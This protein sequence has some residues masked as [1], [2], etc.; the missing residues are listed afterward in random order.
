MAGAIGGPLIALDMRTLYLKGL[1]FFGC[2]WL[3]REVFEN[4]VGYIER[5]EIRPLVSRIYP[6][7]DI[8]QAQQDFMDKKFVGKLVLLPAA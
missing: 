6:L 7:A 5:G 2:T 8:V 1:N 3:P 4:L